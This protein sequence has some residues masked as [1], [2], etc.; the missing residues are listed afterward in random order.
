MA[1]GAPV[2]RR[3]APF[4]ATIAGMLGALLLA[5]CGSD[6]PTDTGGLASTTSTTIDAEPPPEGPLD[7]L[8]SQRIGPLEL[9]RHEGAPEIRRIGAED[10]RNL[11]YVG[12]GGDSVSVTLARFP[13]PRLA[14]GYAAQYASVLASDHGFEIKGKPEGFEGAAGSGKL[15]Q[16]SNG[17]GIAAAVWTTGPVFAAALADPSTVATVLDDAPFGRSR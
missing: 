13:T 7:R 5:A 14:R 16:L 11:D 9:D 12:D 17:K 2:R 15:I 10:A 3:R 8:V 1:K 6:Q 4:A